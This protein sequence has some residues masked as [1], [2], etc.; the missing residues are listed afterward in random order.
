MTLCLFESESTCVPFGE[1]GEADRK[2]Y[3]PLLYSNAFYLLL[4]IKHLL[5]KV[6]LE[7]ITK[8]ETFKTIT[9]TEICFV[10]CTG[11]LL[12]TFLLFCMNPA[13]IT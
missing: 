7:L 5:N 13:S 11:P 9:C 1:S 10:K 12:L 6:V 4:G 8:K 3:T 2:R